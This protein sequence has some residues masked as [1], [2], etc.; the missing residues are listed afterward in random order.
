MHFEGHEVFETFKAFFGIS[1]QVKVGAMIGAHANILF[2][3]CCVLG[4]GDEMAGHTRMCR[5]SQLEVTRHGVLAEG[6]MTCAG[7]YR[8]R[9]WK[10][11]SRVR[12]GG[13]ECN[14]EELAGK[15]R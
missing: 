8:G 10:L 7:R 13:P 2:Q 5:A 14:S 6:W 12:F 4:A 1:D 15:C 9:F 3:I 11:K